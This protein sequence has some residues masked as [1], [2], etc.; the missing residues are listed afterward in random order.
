MKLVL[1][2]IQVNLDAEHQP[3]RIVWRLRP[4]QIKAIH[5]VWTWRG[6]WWNTPALRGNRR[7]Y[8]RV[9][10]TSYTGDCICLEIFY[11]HGLWTLSRILD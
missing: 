9:D 7:L 10:C 8:Y 6:Q 11:Q 5:E 1:E 2:P 4:Y 3:Q